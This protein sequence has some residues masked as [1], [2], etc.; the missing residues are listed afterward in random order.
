MASRATKGSPSGLQVAFEALTGWVQTQTRDGMG[1]RTPTR[2][3]RARVTLV[4]VHPD[5]QL[6]GRRCRSEH[7]LPPPTADVNL[8]YAMVA[9]VIVWVNV[10]GDPRQGL[11]EGYFGHLAQPY[12]AMAPIEII[13]LY[14]SPADLARPAAVGQHLRRRDHGL[15]HRADAR[16]HR[17]GCPTR[18][19]KL[20]DM[21]IGVIQALIFTLLTII[22]FS[23]CGRQRRRR[24]GSL[25]PRA[26][27]P[28]NRTTDTPRPVCR[29]RREGTRR[30]M[31]ATM[32]LAQA[33]AEGPERHAAGSGHGR[34][35]YR[36]RRRRARCGRR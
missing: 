22:Y 19:W 14:F 28:R 1:L 36:H 17:C 10:A 12:V 7:Y 30:D 33:A 23:D 24:R 26:R 25:E 11:G 2:R 4:R 3:D 29:S 6:A 9:F 35:W 15:D 32:V 8:V 13:T 34:R 20:F 31:S 21:F 16:L 18:V 5:L 27:A